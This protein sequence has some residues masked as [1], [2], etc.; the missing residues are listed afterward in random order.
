MGLT[1][2]ATL[3]VAAASQ[4][5]KTLDSTRTRLSQI[6]Q[7]RRSIP[8]VC[9]SI[10]SHTCASTRKVTLAARPRCRTDGQ[11][12]M[13]NRPAKGKNGRGMSPEGRHAGTK[14]GS[15]SAAVQTLREDWSARYS[16]Q[17]LECGRS[18]TA[19]SGARAA[20]EVPQ[21]RCGWGCLLDDDPR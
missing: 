8:D 12:S 21:P 9:S 11:R 14:S 13:S 4:A 5:G 1:R 19:V 2:S 6:P 17:R 18:S 20:M 10:R 16:R 3:R 15:E 7:R